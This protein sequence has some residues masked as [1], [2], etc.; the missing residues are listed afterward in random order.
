MLTVG[1]DVPRR[2]LFKC[3]LRISGAPRLLLF[4]YCC[5]VVPAV[6]DTFTLLTSKDAP[7][8]MKRRRKEETRGRNNTEPTRN[9]IIFMKI[10]F[11]NG[12]NFLFFVYIFFFVI[13]WGFCIFMK[14]RKFCFNRKWGH[15][16][17]FIDSAD[18]CVSIKFR[19]SFPYHQLAYDW[20]HWK[21]AQF[22]MPS[23]A[24]DFLNRQCLLIIIVYSFLIEINYWIEF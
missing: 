8:K 23:F 6:D 7:P 24:D 4:L 2:D 9:R 11:P 21:V 20:P 15:V 14:V 12:E 13:S 17:S 1:R 16:V 19:S 5:L 18:L 22:S 10:I 3:W